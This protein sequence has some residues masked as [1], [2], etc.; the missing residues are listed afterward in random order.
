MNVHQR[1]GLKFERIEQCMYYADNKLFLRSSRRTVVLTITFLVG[2]LPPDDG[3]VVSNAI[4]EEFILN[5]YHPEEKTDEHLRGL[6]IS[7][8]I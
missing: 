4:S 3:V 1:Y 8:E 2:A 7:K 6:S 5:D